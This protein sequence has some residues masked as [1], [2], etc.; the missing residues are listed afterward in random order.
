[1]FVESR[2]ISPDLRD[3]VIAKF[4]QGPIRSHNRE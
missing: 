2:Y 3:H 1:M 4:L